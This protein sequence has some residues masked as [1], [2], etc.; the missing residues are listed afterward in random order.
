M[1]E[2][3]TESKTDSTTDMKV[4]V[5]NLK[6]GN[7][8]GFKKGKR[9]VVL[10]EIKR[11]CIEYL[12]RG[13][14]DKCWVIQ[15]DNNIVT[16]VLYFDID[17]MSNTFDNTYNFILK[18]LSKFYDKENL[19]CLGWRRKDGS[20]KY[21]IYFVNIFVTKN[22]LHK[23]VRGINE[24]YGKELV[25]ATC[26][27]NFI[28]FEGFR[29]V[30]KNKKFVVGSE[31]EVI[32]YFKDDTSELSIE[33]LYESI[34]CF[35]EPETKILI[36]IADNNTNK[37][38]DSDI[39]S[40]LANTIF[41][42]RCKWVATRRSDN[43]FMLQH[44]SQQCLVKNN[45]KHSQQN[46]SCAFINKYGQSIVECYAHKRKV[47]QTTTELKKLKA[48]LRLVNDT[49]DLNDFE[50]LCEFMTEYAIKHNLKRYNG[51]IM[52]PNN[53]IPIIY[54]NWI[55]YKDFL[56]TIFSDKTNDTV[57]RLFRKST[58]HIQNL[59]KYL[60]NIEHPD[61][62]FLKINKHIFA[63]NNGYLNIED[64]YNIQFHN[65]SI[66]DNI[67]TT[68]YYPVEFDMNWLNSDYKFETPIFDKIC[69]YH[70]NNSCKDEYRDTDEKT[71]EKSEEKSEEE[72][73]TPNLI[74][75]CF[76]G[77]IG[78][79]HYPIHKYDKFNC[80]LYIKGDTNTGK[81]TTGNIIMSSHQNVGT[82]SGKMED[83]F[84]L[85][86][87]IKRNVIYVQEC[88]KN[89]HLK[90]DK[91]DF[92]RMIEGSKISV[93]RKGLTAISDF[94]WLI[95]MLWLGNFY[96]KYIDTCGAIAR[97]ICGFYMDTPIDSTKQ[98][99]SLEQE[100]TRNESHLLLLK[101]LFMY[102]WLIKY[103]KNKTFQNW[104]DS[105]SYF[106]KAENEIKG[107]VSPL[108]SF[109]NISYGNF[110]YWYIHSVNDKDVIKVEGKDGFLEKYNR[111]CYLNKYPQIK[112]ATDLDKS[113]L[114]NK[115]Y[116]LKKDRV[117]NACGKK[118]TGK[119]RVENQCCNQYSNKNRGRE[120]FIT[121]IKLVR[122]C[123]IDDNS[124]NESVEED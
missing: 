99:T 19:G 58:Q 107:D 39:I 97:R 104:K 93:S 88:P 77:M 31:Y 35:N 76:L 60:E 102:R 110:E 120:W 65:Y 67:A 37:S 118:P 87:L 53:N 57:F 73:N 116:I 36:P 66:T 45:H 70:F 50:I 51:F 34:Y 108:Y 95:P 28:R 64:L 71:N 69:M 113:I 63:F 112:K 23:I 83:T 22:R 4:T 105:I 117:C 124:D 33:D 10:N 74:Y 9:Y 18:Y 46:H 13:E 119:R 111:W 106:A 123:D 82:I 55:E 92:Q 24:L 48:K 43:S 8:H 29:K 109:L 17:N 47:I 94:L 85:E 54:S 62:S 16:T 115:G 27:T 49:T 12:E 40:Q 72:T 90:L 84:G 44:D 11:E 56:N 78:R 3:K 91:T 20:T 38:N 32:Q 101:S 26:I 86:G 98:D 6:G 14:I 52:K 2:S 80:V 121:N 21:H 41:D 1:E 79:L 61:F 114:N 68:I 89:I 122:K 42:T 7:K 15:K 103:F 5:L 81:S 100:C 75:K 25:D 59:L 30:D 96:P